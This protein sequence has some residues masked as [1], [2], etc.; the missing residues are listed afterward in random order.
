[1]R[2]LDT[3]IEKII[4]KDRYREDKGDIEG[5]SA[6]IKEKGLLQPIVL[7]QKLNLLAGERRYLA[8]QLAGLKTIPTF[9]YQV[10]GKLDPLEIELIENT[11]RKDFT[12]QERARLERSIFELK[13][14]ADPNWSGR[15]QAEAR[16]ESNSNINRRLQIAEA[17]ELLP[18]L[19]EC[20]TEDD[21]WKE[22]SKLKERVVIDELRKRV[23]PA[24]T[25]ASK[26]AQDHYRVGD[27]FDGMRKCK[28]ECAHFAEVDPPYGVDLG[29]VKSRNADKVEIGRYSEIDATEYEAFFTKVATEVFR[30]L[31]KDAFAVFWFGP[32]WQSETLG[33]LRAA[34]FTVPDIPAIWTKGAVGQTASPDTTFGSC[35]EPFWLARKG[36]PK[37]AKPGR[38]N[39]FEG[40]APVSYAKKI[41]ATE[42]PLG[43][44][45]DVLNTILLPGSAILIPFLGSGVTLRAAYKLGH[46]GWG[47]DLDQTNKELFLGKVRADIEAQ[48]RDKAAA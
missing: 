20:K 42:K 26:W 32:T 4:V 2:V 31:R 41:H 5:L 35:Y 47:Y 17:M 44:L 6:S 8:C 37:L 30:I 11:Q 48:E 25:Q 43:L 1:M 29:K 15:K 34:G 10:K 3:P 21:A 27:A 13:V 23:N 14:K 45:E 12:W 46:T 36:K 24:I 33:I 19:A 38:G 16:D 9:I 18:E 7:D 39:V 40:F 22:F 28:A